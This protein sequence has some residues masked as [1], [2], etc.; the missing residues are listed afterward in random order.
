MIDDD[1]SMLLEEDM[2]DS[3][4]QS[5]HFHT[6][7]Y[8]FSASVTPGHSMRV[9]WPAIAAISRMIGLSKSARVSPSPSSAKNSKT[10]KNI[11]I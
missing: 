4:A 6:M 3:A 1:P 11:I 10:T 5:T 8:I 9:S 7:L 2:E